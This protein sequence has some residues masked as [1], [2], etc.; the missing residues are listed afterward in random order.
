MAREIPSMVYELRVTIPPHGTDLCLG[1][2]EKEK[3][4]FRTIRLIREN[5]LSVHYE[6]RS[7]L[8]HNPRLVSD[9]PDIRC[10]L[11]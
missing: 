4:M 6:F 7:F 9:T 10:K 5:N 3:D 1:L 2:F 8:R 11:F